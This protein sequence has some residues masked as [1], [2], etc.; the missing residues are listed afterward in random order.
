L[1]EAWWE[2]RGSGVTIVVRQ[3][4]AAWM[5]VAADSVA[6]ETKRSERPAPNCPGATVV[7]EVSLTTALADMIWTRCKEVAV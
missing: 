5:E 3:G 2:R 7:S 6:A 1:R 4:L